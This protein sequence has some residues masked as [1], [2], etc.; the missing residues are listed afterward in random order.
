MI[1]AHSPIRYN[2]LSVLVSK[3]GNDCLAH[4]QALTQERMHCSKEQG[5]T[6]RRKERS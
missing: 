2:A 6:E 4:M 1:L 5:E 3:A